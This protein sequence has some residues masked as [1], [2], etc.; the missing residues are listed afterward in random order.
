M[1]GRVRE[2]VE[3]AGALAAGAW[4]DAERV[5]C[6]RYGMPREYLAPAA[7][8]CAVVLVVSLLLL[9]RMLRRSAPSVYLLGLSGAGKTAF[10][11]QMRDNKVGETHTS[12]TE[13]SATVSLKGRTVRLVDAPGHQRV[14]SKWQAL[15]QR[16]RPAA[17]VY[18]VDSARF[19]ERARE[20]ANCLV[21]VL[22]DPLL[23]GRRVPTVVFCNK[24]DVEGAASKEEITAALEKEIEG[25]VRAHLLSP[26]EHDAALENVSSLVG[27]DGHFSFARAVPSLRFCGGSVT[28]GTGVDA[29]AAALRGRV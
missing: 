14:R 23:F 19:V 8:A 18:I 7:V 2:V 10:F 6:G 28:A 15:A 1:E 16:S 29:L 27:G 9:L 22:G 21:R 13:N 24:Q 25:V 11:L 17:I 20:E 3:R 5:A 4:A 26:D 12:I